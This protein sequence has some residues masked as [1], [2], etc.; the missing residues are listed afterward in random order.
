MKVP[1][2]P[3]LFRFT[4]NKSIEKKYKR[5]LRILTTK[6]NDE[7]KVMFCVFWTCTNNAVV[8]S[9]STYQCQVKYND[10][11]TNNSN[12]NKTRDRYFMYIV[13]VYNA[14]NSPT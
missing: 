3:L 6:K 2:M 1:K 4:R 13:Y 9:C 11:N 8:T 10:I 14:K 7:K 5:K 12:N